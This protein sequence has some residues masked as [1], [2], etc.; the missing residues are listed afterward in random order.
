MKIACLP[1][2]PIQENTYVVWDDTRE[3][4]IIDAGNS[5]PREDAA[6]DNF[7]AQEGLKPVLAANTH[8]HFDH[9]MGVEHLRQRYGIPFALSGKDRFLLENA[10]TSG[11]VFGVKIGTMPPV[12]RDLDAEEEIRF[13]R[14]ALR[15]LR[16]PGHTPGHVAF[17]EPQSKALFTG[18]TLFR[19]SIGRTD[20]PGGDYSWI[21][22]SILDVILPLGD[23][24]HVYPGHGPETTLGHETLYNPFIVEVLNGEVNYRER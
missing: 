2:N 16:T 13:G 18:D 8:G 11:A 17:Y 23:E 3:C 9:T 14:T 4:V 6:L 7:I 12:D 20:L 21:M 1:F 5:S 10:A 15:I 24:V 22:R 19:E